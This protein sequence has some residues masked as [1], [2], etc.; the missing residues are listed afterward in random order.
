MSICG[1]ICFTL[2]IFNAMKTKSLLSIVICA[3]TLM[4]VNAQWQTNADT[5]FTNSGIVKIG[6]I[7]DWAQYAKLNVQG[8]INIEPSSIPLTGDWG[9]QINLNSA[10][11]TGGQVYKISSLGGN[12]A[13]GQGKFLIRNENGKAKLLLDS[14][15]N[16]GI[17][18]NDPAAKLDVAGNAKINSQSNWGS[19][20]VGGFL[21]VEP[22]TLTWGSQIFMSTGDLEGGQSYT[23]SSLAGDAGEGQGKFLIRNNNGR[24][25]LLLDSTGNFGIGTND[26]ASKLHVSNGDIYI[27]EIDRGIIMK[28]PDGQCW[29]G[30]LNNSGTLTFAMIDCP[31]N[32]VTRIIKEN[33]N[34]NVSVFPNPANTNIS[35]GIENY[36]NHL[37]SASIVTIDGKFVKNISITSAFSVFD[38]SSLRRNA[39]VFTLKDINGNIVSSVKFMKE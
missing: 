27:D 29:R 31:G 28:S 34:L 8:I 19:L 30:T 38:I 33:Y 22:G 9:T 39:Y 12:A 18:I 14:L 21:L 1:K 20:N 7:S 16:F 36:N 15:G 17:G 10:S 11:L 24:S 35:V 13:E 25:K 3:I 23:I 4:N 37:L 6:Q 2:L 5:L 32:N 26:P